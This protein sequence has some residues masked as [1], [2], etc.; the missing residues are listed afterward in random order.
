MTLNT[1]NKSIS[2]DTLPFCPFSSEGRRTMLTEK[3]APDAP[4]Q[5]SGRESEV[6]RLVASGLSNQAVAD[7]LG[8][9]ER[10]AREYVARILLKLR[11]RSRVQA[12]VI[13][14]EWRM[15]ERAG[16]GRPESGIVPDVS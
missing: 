14:T 12:A 7:Q 2:V 8:I 11:V 3:R 9:S 1:C 10:T 16:Y 4:I 13:A 15:T 5:L 6:L